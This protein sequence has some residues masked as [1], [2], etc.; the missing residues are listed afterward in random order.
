MSLHE[1]TRDT[2]SNRCHIAMRSAAPAHAALPVLTAPSIAL[3][4]PS[5]RVT[6]GLVHPHEVHHTVQ[7]GPVIILN[8]QAGLAVGA[9]PLIH[10]LHT[11]TP[12]AAQAQTPDC[13][14]EAQG[15]GLGQLAHY[16]RCTTPSNVSRLELP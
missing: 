5:P 8:S 16:T 6:C 2:Q 14:F 4:P 13:W 10:N 12:V 1:C 15:L 7:A 11:Q 9:Q 3:Q